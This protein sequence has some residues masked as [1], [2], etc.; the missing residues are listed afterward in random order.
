V[1]WPT[2]DGF[3]RVIL[4]RTHRYV[5]IYFIGAPSREQL[6]RDCERLAIRP[7]GLTAVIINYKKIKHDKKFQ[8]TPLLLRVRAPTRS[9]PTKLDNIIRLAHT[10]C[11]L[12]ET[13]SSSTMN[14]VAADN[15]KK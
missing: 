5:Y 15:S 9:I 13:H 7:N 2:S 10:T 14:S 6:N 3:K 1:A 11:P 8:V 4:G 12:R